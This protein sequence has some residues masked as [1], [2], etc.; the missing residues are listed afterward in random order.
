[1]AF[2]SEAHT[3]SREENAS[4]KTRSFGSDSIQNGYRLWRQM[5]AEIST[6]V[7]VSIATTSPPIAIA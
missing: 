5:A 3:D 6:S 4:N 7:W 1:M 2:S